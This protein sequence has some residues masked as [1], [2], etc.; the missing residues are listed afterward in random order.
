MEP[1]LVKFGI[2]SGELRDGFI[3]AGEW[4][5]LRG[6]D[7]IYD[8]GPG[9]AAGRGRQPPCPRLLLGSGTADSWGTSSLE[10]PCPAQVPLTWGMFFAEEAPRKL[11]PLAG[12]L[13][14]TQLL[15]EA[16]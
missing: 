1:H 3:K 10:W 2:C 12:V 13:Q 14:L 11:K 5:H 9:P 4:P 8:L 15:R 16:Q 7:V 6:R